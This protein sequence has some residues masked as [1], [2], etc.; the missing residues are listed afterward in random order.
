MFNLHFQQSNEWLYIEF[1]ASRLAAPR[2]CAS[3]WFYCQRPCSRLRTASRNGSNSSRNVVIE[4]SVKP[5]DARPSK[6]P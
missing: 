2:F 6:L 3:S 5:L 1:G 4:V